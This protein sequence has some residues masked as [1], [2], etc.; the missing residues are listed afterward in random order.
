MGIGNWIILSSQYQI[1]NYISCELGVEIHV[2]SL[3]IPN[4]YFWATLQTLV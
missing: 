3:I 1:P 2:I 4:F